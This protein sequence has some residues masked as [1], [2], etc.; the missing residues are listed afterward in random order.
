MKKS[1]ALDQLDYLKEIIKNTKLTAI[2]GYPYMI[3]WGLIWIIGYISTIWLSDFV[4]MI[5]S[6][7]GGLTSAV[8]G[9]KWPWK[10]N[11]DTRLLIK[12]F[13]QSG[14]VILVFIFYPLFLSSTSEFYTNSFSFWPILLAVIYI[15]WGIMI[16]KEMIIIGVFLIITSL[17][18][19]N[20]TGNLQNLWYAITCGG[21]LTSFGIYCRAM[22]KKNE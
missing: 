16:G 3:L 19:M 1:E 9:I 17:I 14:V 21:T 13:L 18:G 15:L 2:D 12:L 5:L 20:F 8:I 11:A 10:K 4:W 22:V 6:T 7:L